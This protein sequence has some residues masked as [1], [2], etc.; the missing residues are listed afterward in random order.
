[1]WHLG[2]PPA[3]GGGDFKGFGDSGSGRPPC[4]QAWEVGAGRGGG[5]PRPTAL[6]FEKSF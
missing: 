6:S 1:M 2:R 4:G 5:C 3:I